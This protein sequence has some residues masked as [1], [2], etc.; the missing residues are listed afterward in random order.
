MGL[1]DECMGKYFEKKRGYIWAILTILLFLFIFGGVEPFI[2]NNVSSWDFIIVRLSLA[3]IIVMVV[4]III[5][6]IE[7]FRK[8]VSVK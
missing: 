2:T 3:F 1:G 8:R 4:G 7:L 5:W 6:S